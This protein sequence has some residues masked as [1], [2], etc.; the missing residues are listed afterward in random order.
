MDLAS[1]S[2]TASSSIEAG[3]PV[4]SEG[5]ASLGPLSF[6]CDGTIAGQVWG[7]GAA[8]GRHLLHGGLLQRPDV[9][10]IGSGTGVAGL[11]SAAAGANSVILTDRADVVP[12]LRAMIGRNAE[13]LSGCECS[14]AALEWGDESAVP[15]NGAD[16]ILAADVLYSAEHE[17][18]EALRSTMIACAR[19][20]DGTILHCYEERWPKIVA[21]WRDGVSRCGQMRLVRETV[22]E[23]PPGIDRRLVLEEIKLTEDGLFS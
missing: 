5:V 18:H 14:A 23:S 16:L 3:C 2:A 20:R 17:V 7:A 13:A 15:E 10:E 21:M 22:L 9:I 11:A 1:A 19:P 12:M 8:L 6:A 4:V